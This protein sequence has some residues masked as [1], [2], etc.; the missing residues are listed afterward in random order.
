MT[1]F[2]MPTPQAL[3]NHTVE[4]RCKPEYHRFLIGKNGA[5]I[6]KVRDQFGARIMFPQKSSDEEPELVTIIGTKEKAEA[7][8]QHLQKLIKDL[9]SSGTEQPV[10]I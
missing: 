2:T 5:N 10:Y 3:Q 6:R 4:I 9:V 1:T 7:A 8:R